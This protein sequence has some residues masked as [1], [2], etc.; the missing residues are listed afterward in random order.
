VTTWL[1]LQIDD[2]GMLWAEQKNPNATF[3]RGYK[4]TT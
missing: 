1:T 4:K 3:R 2:K